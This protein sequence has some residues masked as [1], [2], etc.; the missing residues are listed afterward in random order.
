MIETTL[1]GGTVAREMIC[2]GLSEHRTTVESTAAEFTKGCV[3]GAAGSENLPA[4]S[5]GWHSG[6]KERLRANPQTM[7]RDP[8]RRCRLRR[9]ERCRKQRTANPP[10]WPGLVGSAP[11]TPRDLSLWRQSRRATETGRPPVLLGRP[12]SGLGSWR[13]ARVASPRGPVL[14]SGHRPCYLRSPRGTTSGARIRRTTAA[15][16]RESQDE[17][18]QRLGGR[19][20]SR[21]VSSACVIRDPGRSIP[22]VAP[23]LC[24][25]AAPEAVPRRTRSRPSARP[26]R[27]Y[28]SAKTQHQ[29]I[30]QRT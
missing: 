29:K 27:H 12:V 25:S 10:H 2:A 11:Q 23:I 8:E 17:R 21:T 28:P 22:T 24:R 19:V 9:H 18:N 16:P 7:D 3:W 26:S 1:A 5:Q 20:L 15:P 30:W 6:R 4:E 13:G 14:R